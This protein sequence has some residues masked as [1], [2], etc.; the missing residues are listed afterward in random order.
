MNEYNNWKR[1]WKNPMLKEIGK[2]VTGRTPP[3]VNIENFGDEYLFITPSD[4]DGRKRISNTERKL[5]SKGAVVISSCQI[6]S[7]SVCVSCIGWQMGKVAM[8]TKTSFTNQQINTII[9]NE[10][11]V[12]D[13]LHYSLSTRREELKTLGSVGTRTPI[14]K[15]SAFEKLELYLPPYKNQKK[16]ASILSI[17]DD[18]IENNTRRIEILE[19]MA[20]LVYEEWFVKF[21]FPGHK[22]VKMIPSELGEIPEGGKVKT[23]GELGKIVTGKTPST[24]KEENY[25][26]YIPFIKTPDMHGNMFCISSLQCLSKTGEGSQK[27]KTLPANTL[28]VSCI[29]TVGVVSITSTESQTNQQI[30]ALIPFDFE[31]L[32]Y[33]Y[34][35]L[36]KLKTHLE[37]LG[38]NGVTLT[39]VNKEKFQSIKIID[40]DD[41]VKKYHKIASPVFSQ[42]KKL[43]LKNQNLRKTRDLLLPKLI[44]GEIDVSDLDIHIRNEVQEL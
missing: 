9:P 24:K 41:V 36:N 25:G 19:Q 32:E 16:I 44:S 5:S 11:I 17:Y 14:L 3:T 22:N 37:N 7:K 21:R 1:N 27:N 12:P 23:L 13:F 26:N 18:L 33:L 42:I 38:A 40:P 4:M 31:R 15:K 8:T 2:V 34:F 6:P 20:K 28:L 10:N 29:G 43:Q 35:E 30:N 39:N